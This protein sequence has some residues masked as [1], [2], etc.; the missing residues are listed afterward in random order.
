MGIATLLQMTAFYIVKYIVY[1]AIIL[2]AVVLGK[3]WADHSKKEKEKT[4]NQQRKP[5]H[6]QEWLSFMLIVLR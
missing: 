1:I 6:I 3:R 2:G 4:E 5:F